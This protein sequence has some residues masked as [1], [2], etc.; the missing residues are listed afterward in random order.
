MKKEAGFW[1]AWLIIA[2]IICASLFLIF[3][4]L[5]ANNK[6][7]IAMKELDKTL[8]NI[9]ESKIQTIVG[10]TNKPEVYIQKEPSET[11]ELTVTYV[12]DGDTFKI[13]TGQRVRLICINTPERGNYYYKEAKDYLENLVLNKQV[14]LIK[15]VS[16]ND[17]WG[18]LLRY[19]YIGNTFV[20]Y[21]LV[22]NGYAKVDRFPPDT[23]KCDELEEAENKAK[24]N[25]LGIWNKSA[26][27][28]MP[29]SEEIPPLDYICSSNYYNCD[30]FKTHAEAQAVYEGCGGVENDIH[31]LDQDK[32][33]IACESLS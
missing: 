33:G 25:N 13:N 23:S 16:E 12:V 11:S 9:Q 30:D 17:S 21:E 3:S 10:E 22:E 24:S 14:S 31:R 4:S 19:V 32:D 8:Q 6:E 20:N 26:Q 5:D 28:T 7:E 1:W 29:V 2:S 27:T 18:R 15:D